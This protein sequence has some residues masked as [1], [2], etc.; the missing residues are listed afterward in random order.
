MEVADKACVRSSGN[1][2]GQNGL[3]KT[4]RDTAEEKAKEK[5]KGERFEIM[6]NV[7]WAEVGKAIMDELGSTV[8]GAGK[9]DE[10]RK[11]RCTLLVPPLYAHSTSAP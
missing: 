9:P 8:F 5:S 7:L 2:N 3:L 1:K 10:F 11:V 6:A 4:D